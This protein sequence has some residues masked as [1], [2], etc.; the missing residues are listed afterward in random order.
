MMKYNILIIGL[1][2][3]YGNYKLLDVQL[4]TISPKA[5]EIVFKKENII[6]DE[7]LQKESFSS[8]LNKM[9][10]ETRS[11]VI[12]ERQED[13]KTTDDA[14]IDRLLDIFKTQTKQIL[15]S[16]MFTKNITFLHHK[17]Q[18]SVI[19]SYKKEDENLVNNY[20][21]INKQNSAVKYLSKID[22]TLSRP[23]IG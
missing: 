8:L 21:V 19:I 22:S 17:Y 1:L 12:K 18:D 9:S 11:Q 23:K 10:K 5:G 4:K 6:Y 3:L 15:S 13:N 2:L 20:A 16:M 14:E 7:K